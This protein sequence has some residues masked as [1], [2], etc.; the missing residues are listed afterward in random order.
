MDDVRLVWKFEW[1][2]PPKGMELLEAVALL[3]E[4]CHMGMGFD[5][6][7]AQSS[8][9]GIDHFLLLQ[10]VGL[11]ANSPAWCLPIYCYLT[12]WW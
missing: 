4:V 10:D 2:W 3:E 7:Y 5:I 12:P 6:S 9:R 1:K 8:P 11:S